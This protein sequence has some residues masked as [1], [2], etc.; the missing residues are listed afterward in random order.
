MSRAERANLNVAD[1]YD[2][3]WVMPAEGLWQSLD[4]G[5][6]QAAPIR[7]GGLLFLGD[8]WR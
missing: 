2:L 3:I 7:L 8:I 5:N 1:P 6:P 4:S